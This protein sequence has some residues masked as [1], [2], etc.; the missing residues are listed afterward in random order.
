MKAKQKKRI[1]VILASL[2]SM[3]AILPTGIVYAGGDTLPPR[4]GEQGYKG[5]NQPVYH[6]H[7]KQ[8][9]LD[10]TP[11][12]DEFSEFMRAKIPL[13]NRNEAF[14]PTQANPKLDQ[15]VQYLNL[16]GDYGI[17]YMNPTVYND[18]FS[19]YLFNFWQYVDVQASWHGVVTN[20]TPDSLYN[21]VGNWWEHQFE[22]GVLNIPNPA[23][24]NAA[25]KNGVKSVGCIF[26]PRS[27]HTEDYIYKDSN[28]RFPMADK[29]VELAKY[30]G[31]DGYFVNAEEALNASFMPVYQEFIRAMTSQGLYVN[32][33][34]SNLYG[35]TNQSTWGRINYSNKDAK[36][37]SNWV[38][39]PTD[40]TI[41][42]NSLYMNPDPSKAMVDGSV[43]TMK[44]LGLDPR[45]TVFNTLEAGQTGFSGT[46]GAL[47]NTYDENLVPRTGLASLGN[48]TVYD[49][50]DEQLFGHSGPNSY[51]EN[52]RANPDYY[53]YV[54]ARERTWWSGAADAP[55]YN[56]GQGTLASA[57]MTQDQLL[58]AVLDATPDPVKTA[59]DPNRGKPN[60][61]KNYK[62]WPGLA[63][64]IS[65]RSV[66][67]GSNFYTNFN[68]GHGMQY[69]V[70]GEV[71]NDNQWANINIQDILPTWQW[72]ID[73]EGT[74]LKVD[75]DY[76]KKYSAGD[77]YTQLGGYDGGSSLAIFGDL[78]APNFIS[79]YK[80]KLDIKAESKLNITFNKPSVTDASSVKVGLIFE[81][82][83]A[84]VEYIEIPSGANKTTQGWVQKNLD[85]SQFAGKTLAA[86]GLSFTPEQGTIEDY[87]FNVGEINITDSTVVKPAAP[88]GL[89]IDKSFDTSETYISWNLE[90]YSKVQQYNVY[91]EFEHGKEIFLGGTYD[92]R[93]YIKSLYDPKGTVKI[94]VKAVGA[95]GSEGNAAV[96]EK[97][98]SNTVRNIQTVENVGSVDVTWE[99]PAVKYVQA[100]VDVTLNYSVTKDVYSTT[101]AKGTNAVKVE[102]PI[103]DGSTYTVRISLLDAKG[104]VVTYADDTGVLK[105]DHSD[106]YEG[107]A[108]FFTPPLS[109][110]KKIKLSGPT[111]NDWWHLYAWQNGNPIT[112][113]GK[114]Y[115]IR[116]VD[117][118]R[119]LS[120]VGSS[121][122]IEIVLE[123][124]NGNMSKPVQVPFGS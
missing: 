49:H 4:V 106:V 119:A 109:S 27:E 5:K 56:A 123:D 118:L 105:D 12:T 66:I 48:T 82:D 68:T 110:L 73:T 97:D 15:E 57:G 61:G 29:L 35:Q 36:Q 33:Y 3:G 83:P 111:S 58:D 30:Y 80:T 96:V 17:E 13:Q 74:R 92:D 41:A 22:F 65:E 81:D 93:F 20:P 31:F 19:R 59:N 108:T 116:G 60:E 100:K 16:T 32:V 18:Q 25:H 86:F 78:D 28:G 69:F 85:L 114:A 2:L 124:F 14:K 88:T 23:Y 103:A 101:V 24:T 11:E 89:K 52:R 67:D 39:S 112:F 113:N 94:K 54:A 122:V 84:K 95:D 87:Q 70:D 37:F 99:T 71:S 115:A 42:A 77:E 6:G 63:A 50:L 91:A 8:N 120:V 79:L 7:R 44:A 51:T 21:P 62:T 76:G 121:G 34:A 43:A 38:K 46:R 26:F 53:K 75:F 47:Y 55:T 10:W 107:T 1:A 98:F 104:N 9:I 72:R 90:D 64:Y 45:N 102:V 117:D 40:T